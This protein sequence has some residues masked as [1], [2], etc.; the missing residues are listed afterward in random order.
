MKGKIVSSSEVND[1][2]FEGMK[3][4]L[5][6]SGI[7]ILGSQSEYESDIPPSRCQGRDTFLFW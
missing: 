2:F 1:R 6:G 5:W 4:F 7:R 3:D